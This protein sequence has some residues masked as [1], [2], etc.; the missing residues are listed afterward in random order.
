MLKPIDSNE[1]FSTLLTAQTSVDTNNLDESTSE[2]LNESEFI[3]NAPLKDTDVEP[4][5]PQRITT[6]LIL[7]EIHNNREKSFFAR[8]FSQITRG[9]IRSSVFTLFSG[10][11]GA[12]VLSLPHVLYILL[13]TLILLLDHDLL[14]IGFGM[15]FHHL[16]SNPHLYDLQHPEFGHHS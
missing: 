7:E 2:T 3:T 5:P 6:P 8:N 10:T 1:E 4:D 15:R 12:G 13:I 11:V 9:G 14:R 16:V